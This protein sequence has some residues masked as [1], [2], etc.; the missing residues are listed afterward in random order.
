MKDNVRLW[1]FW[2]WE[3]VLTLA[4]LAFAV[5]GLL[6]VPEWVSVVRE[7]LVE[8]QLLAAFVVLVLVVTVVAY[9]LTTGAM[10][11]VAKWLMRLLGSGLVVAFVTLV[12]VLLV[13][14]VLKPEYFDFTSPFVALFV[15][16]CFYGVIFFIRWQTL[17][18]YRLVDQL[19]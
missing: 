12:P 1:K 5:G 13:K 10:V 15:I 9:R 6:F 2:T 11:G 17:L 4:L 7:Q 14:P 3:I 19:R 8:V 18:F 16:W